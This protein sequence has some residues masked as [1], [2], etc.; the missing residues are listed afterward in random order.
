MILSLTRQIVE[1]EWVEEQVTTSRNK[2]EKV[3][4]VNKLGKHVGHDQKLFAFL[5]C[6]KNGEWLPYN[7]KF[8][9][10]SASSSPGHNIY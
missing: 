3:F 9:Q 5:Y 10:K 7:Q 8:N 1:V 2:I 4:S 6:Q